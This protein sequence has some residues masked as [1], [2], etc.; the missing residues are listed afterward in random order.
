[1]SASP[2]PVM[3]HHLLAGLAAVPQALDRP[4]RGLASDSRQVGRGELFLALRGQQHH[5]L[6]FLAAVARAGAAAV[7][8]EPPYPDCPP[9]AADLP[10]FPIE[11]LSHRVGTIA[12]RFYARPGQALELIGVTGTDGKTSTSVYL[13]QALHRR[14]VPSGLLGTLGYGVW[15]ELSE[16]G[17]TTPDALTLWRWLATLRDRGAR[18]VVMEVSSH[19]LA[20]GRVDGLS[21]AVAVL[22]NLSRDH[23]DYHTS[24]AAYAAAKRRLFIELAASHAVLNLDDGFGRELAAALGPRAVGYSLGPNA[25]DGLAGC[26]CARNLQLTP[27]GLRLHITSTWGEG[28]LTSTLLGRFNASNLLAALATLLVLDV[29][30]DEALERLSRVGNAPGRMERFGGAGRPLIVVDYAHTPQALEHALTAL[31]A[32]GNGR[33]WCVFGCGGERDRGKRPLMGGIAERLADQVVITND[34]PRGEDPE[35]IV[36]QILSGLQRPQQARVEHDRAAAIRI[37]LNGAGAGDRVLIAGK[38]HEQYQ[39]LGG[40]RLPFSDQAVVRAWLGEQTP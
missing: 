5:G 20:Q 9:A 36:A 15:G 22:T 17:L 7:A 2:A 8:W 14:G 30:L 27:T 39:L 18:R 24:P 19:A 35:T 40:R 31:R 26:V 12:E 28:E 32:H 21:F 37:A 29:P 23:L 4:V 1:M 3:L 6:D 25:G 11:H 34:N 38:G 16:T 13:A 33:L 10:L